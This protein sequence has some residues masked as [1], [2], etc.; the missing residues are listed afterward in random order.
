MLFLL[1]QMQM[2][3]VIEYWGSSLYINQ[4][5]GN[6]T[7]LADGTISYSSGIKGKWADFDNDGDMD[8]YVAAGDYN[9]SIS[10]QFY[11]NEDGKSFCTI[12][13]LLPP[14]AKQWILD[15]HIFKVL[16]E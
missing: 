9:W 5:N 11:V 8:M 16:I 12:E 4:G 7:R 2:P 10:N 13:T 15:C 1:S 3:H 6:F 14:F